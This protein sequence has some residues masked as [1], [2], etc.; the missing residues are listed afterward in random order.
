MK[1]E[2]NEDILMTMIC[3]EKIWRSIEE[4]SNDN[5]NCNEEEKWQW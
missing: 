2:N 1:K 4:N 3:N 5:D